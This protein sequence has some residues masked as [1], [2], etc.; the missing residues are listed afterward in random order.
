MRHLTVEV[1]DLTPGTRLLAPV[2]MAT[3]DGAVAGVRVM[4]GGRI[5][6]VALEAELGLA[7][8]Q[9]EAAGGPL[10]LSHVITPEGMNYPEAVFAP[11]VTP[12]TIAAEA[13]AQASVEAAHASGGG[14]AGIA[15]LVAEAE[16]RFAY[17]HPEHRFND[18]TEAVPY[19]SCGT[20]PGSC[21]DINTYLI[22]SLRAAGY[23]AGYLY[24]YFF[25][26]EKG[27]VTHDMHCWVV[28]RHDGDVQHWD[29]AHHMKA[30]LGPTRAGLNPRPGWRVA[31]GHSM[32]HVYQQGGEALRLK[33]LVEPVAVTGGGTCRDVAIVARLTAP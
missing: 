21:V 31:L 6:G 15:A 32:G 30:G 10:T 9:I 33:L 19:L 2:G 13:L 22:A 20:T 12:Y 25:P 29:I 18:G 14:M 23:E 4:T 28:T 7:A 1:A 26:A 24:G 11:R 3:P 5:K 17:A 8:L 16:A 27:G